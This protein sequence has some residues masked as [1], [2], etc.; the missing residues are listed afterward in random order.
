MWKGQ[1]GGGGKDLRVVV[2]RWSTNITPPLHP[3]SLTLGRQ[4]LT[5]ISHCCLIMFELYHFLYSLIVIYLDIII[6]LVL[7]LLCPF[8][9]FFLF[10]SSCSDSAVHLV[11]SR[12]IL[13]RPLF[14]SLTVAIFFC[15]SYLHCIPVSFSTAAFLHIYT[16]RPSPFHF[17]CP[18]PPFLLAL[19]LA[20]HS[21][22]R[23]SC[24]GLLNH[25]REPPPR[26]LI[27][28]QNCAP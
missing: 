9:H 21:P 5:L 12:P 4:I 13:V 10:S 22:P 1:E 15:L 18:L 28:L 8:L 26:K 20:S 6:T 27:L 25:R 2:V 23:P 14:S 17:T 3:I 24:R 7:L 16:P 11:L 19:L